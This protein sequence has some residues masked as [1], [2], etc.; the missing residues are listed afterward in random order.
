MQLFTITISSSFLTPK[1]QGFPH[2]SI[3]TFVLPNR[4]PSLPIFTS[5]TMTCREYSRYNSVAISI[6]DASNES[7]N[8]I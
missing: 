7:F 2:N 8:V 6:P 3:R 4:S 5:H 1:T